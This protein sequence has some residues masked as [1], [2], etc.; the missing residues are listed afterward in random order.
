[1]YQTHQQ[2][3]DLGAIL[4]QIEQ[5]VLSMKNRLLQTPFTD[6]VI[7]R[8]AGLPQKQREPV[9]VVQQ[10]CDGSTQ[11]GVRLNLLVQLSPKPLVQLVQ[12]VELLV[13]QEQRELL[14]QPDLR[15]RQV[16]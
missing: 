15:V 14:V 9:P 10:V 1:M 3:P 11:A 13:I 6:V 12:P 8:C 7:K 2:V 5:T 16:Q 4:R